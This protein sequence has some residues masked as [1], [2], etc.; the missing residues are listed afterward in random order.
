MFASGSVAR[1]ETRVETFTLARFV[2][3]RTVDVSQ[4]SL[5]IEGSTHLQ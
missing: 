5:D 4:E 2:N 3:A 1:V